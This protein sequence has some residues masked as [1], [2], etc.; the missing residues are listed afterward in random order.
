MG[1]GER[2]IP[3]RLV[4]G[5]RLRCSCSGNFSFFALVGD[6]DT[7]NGLPAGNV[8][9]RA[10]QVNI[11]PFGL[12]RHTEC[13]IVTMQLADKWE[14]P[15]PQNECIN[16][17]EIIT[18]DSY[19]M[20]NTQSGKIRAYD[21]GQDG[22]IARQWAFIQRMEYMYPGLYAALL[23]PH[24]SLYLPAD[25]E[26]HEEALGFLQDAINFS[27]GSIRTITAL[28]RSDLL[29]PM[30]LSVLCRLAP[31]FI[32][33]TQERVLSGMENIIGMYG[34]ESDADPE[35]L[36][37]NMLALLE[38][39]RDDRVRAVSESSG[40]FLSISWQ[41]EHSHI[42]AVFAEL[43]TTAAYGAMMFA[44]GLGGGRGG[45]AASGNRVPARNNN[46]Q[47]GAPSSTNPANRT[48]VSD[49]V[50]AINGAMISSGTDFKLPGPIPLEWSRNW[51][52]D[53]SLIGHL[54]HGTRCNYEM[55]IKPIEEDGVLAVYLADGRVA[56]FPE[57]ED[58]EKHF[59]YEEKLELSRESDKYCLFDYATRYKYSFSQS[60]KGCHI[61][62]VES[63][64]LK[65]IK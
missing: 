9:H 2:P 62:C 64:M 24:T 59:N 6:R 43:T 56:V 63:V 25:L 51:Y 28:D 52:S 13:S 3:E 32:A 15:A 18:T 37:N 23:S 45:T 50:D 22:E 29:G 27:G 14:N 21:S 30:V 35:F 12:C 55:G 5:A 39:V 1:G 54:G 36:D 61:S 44:C 60:E 19:L 4:M 40:S 10:P 49:P 34:L 47:R 57:L 20:C 58:R 46:A 41:E 26:L 17:N 8:T 31:Q 7:I 42:S 33:P 11:L 48:V 65:G 16:G 38:M 53:S